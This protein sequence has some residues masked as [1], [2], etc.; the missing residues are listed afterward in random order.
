ML[1]QDLLSLS[2]PVQ[3]MMG[4]EIHFLVTQVKSNEKYS[5]WLNKKK[6]RVNLIVF[7]LHCLYLIKLSWD[8]FY[9]ELCCMSSF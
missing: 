3:S 4:S 8:H 7:K 9:Q 2:S 1:F 6:K 5:C